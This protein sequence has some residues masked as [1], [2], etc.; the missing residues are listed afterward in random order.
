MRRMKAAAPHVN[1]SL[2]IHPHSLTWS[3]R[4]KPMLLRVNSCRESMKVPILALLLTV[5]HRSVCK[6]IFEKK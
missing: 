1:A 4:R 6:C 2:G 5:K 3:N